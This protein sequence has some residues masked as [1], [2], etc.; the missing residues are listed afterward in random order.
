[1]SV[2]VVPAIEKK[3]W[4]T[5]GDQV[6]DW[7]EA[8]LVFGPGDLRGEP[9]RLDDEKRALLYRMYEVFPKGHKLAGRRRFRRAAV[10]LRK[11]SAKSEFAAWLAAAE[12]HPAAPVRF[13]GWDRKGRPG[14]GVGVVDPYLPLVAYTEEQ[15]EDLVYGALRVVLELS[16]S[17]RG[18]F[19]I[20]LERIMRIG[21]DGKAVALAAAPDARDGARTTFQVLDETH[22]FTLPRLKQAHR[23]MLANLP[24]RKMAD[25]WSLEITTAPSP[26]EGSVA[27]DTMEY[28]K[29]V[30]EGRASDS[31]FFFFHRQATEGAHDLETEKGVRTAVLEASGPV[32]AWSDIEGIVDQWKDPTA[33]R[34]YLSRVW[35]NKPVRAT[36]R[37][38]DVEAWRK[39][40]RKNHK[41]EKGAQVAL[42][43]DGART[44]DSTAL[45]ATEIA[46]GYQFRLGLWERPPKAAEGWEVPVD[47]VNDVVAQ[48]FKEFKVWRLYAD[49]PYWETVVAEWA[50]KHGEDRVVVWSTYR[51][52]AM[53]HAVKGF[54]NAIGAGDLSHSGDVDYARHIGNTFRR[55]LQIRDDLGTPL[56]TIQK[57]R[58]DS[59]NKIDMAAAGILSWEAR[60]DALAAG[61]GSKKKSVYATRGLLTV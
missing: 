20:G 3:P 33:D 10:S 37:A 23:T 44:F 27:E 13:S 5:L 8:H 1:V 46:T 11:G 34:A 35:L 30:A 32:A 15:S 54:H 4:P 48:A 12:L 47:E 2:L 24:K 57:E 36:A 28:A 16:P 7:I 6:A 59:P 53:A 58:S 22:R 40:I 18:A 42:G 25:P 41:V 49:P 31:R 14:P 21:G 55:N 52:R 9:A 39:L 43:F 60:T 19:D 17:V 45:I 26:G 61:I 56:W 38:F 50:G 29:A 51:T